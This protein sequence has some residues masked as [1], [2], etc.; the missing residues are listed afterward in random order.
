[1]SAMASSF[2]TP[3]SMEEFDDASCTDAM[4]MSMINDEVKDSL[5]LSST[6]RKKC[7][8]MTLAIS[9]SNANRMLEASR[10]LNASLKSQ[11]V[12]S[13]SESSQCNQS[14][15]NNESN[16]R[17]GRN[18]HL[19][20]SAFAVENLVL[21]AKQTSD[22]LLLSFV[23]SMQEDVDNRLLS[24]DEMKL[25]LLL[26]LDMDKSSKLLT[27]FEVLNDSDRNSNSNSKI[28]S[29]SNSNN[30]DSNSDSVSMNSDS[31]NIDD[32]KVK[33]EQQVLN[34]NS[35]DTFDSKKGEVPTKSE[36]NWTSMS[37]SEDEKTPQGKTGSQS[38]SLALPTLKRSQMRKLFQSFLST[39]SVCINYKDM[40]KH[41]Q[42]QLSCRQK[43]DKDKGSNKSI[44]LDENDSPRSHQNVKLEENINEPVQANPQ[45]MNSSGSTSSPSSNFRRDWISI[46]RDTSR[47]IEDIANH[48]TDKVIEDI[49]KKTKIA[50][51]STSSN[52]A[53]PNHTSEDFIIEF[54]KFG[55][56]YNSGGFSLVPWLELL[57]LA[58][59]DYAGRAA[60]SAAAAASAKEKHQARSSNSTQH[61]Q[62]RVPPPN[63]AMD[64]IME[65]TVSNMMP[66]SMESGLSP[67]MPDL[68]LRSPTASLMPSAHKTSSPLSKVLITF[69][70]AGSSDCQIKITTENLLQLQHLVTV[71]DLSRRSPGQVA[72]VLLR[73]SKR[74]R[75]KTSSFNSSQPNHEEV[76]M[77]LSR[78]DF[79]H[80]IRDLIPSETLRR[81]SPPEL[82][83]VMN[84]FSSFFLCFGMMNAKANVSLGV[85]HVNAKE[86]AVGLSF[87]CSGN[88][89]AK[90][91]STFEL[92]GDQNFAHLS[93]RKLM[94]YLRSYLT[95]LVSISLLHSSEASTIDTL[96]CLLAMEKRSQLNQIKGRLSRLCDTVEIGARWTLDHFTQKHLTKRK[97]N[98]QGSSGYENKIFFE[99]FAS[100]YTDGG[101]TIAPWLEFLDLKKFML[102]LNENEHTKFT[103]PT[104]KQN[105]E[106]ALNSPSESGKI[107]TFDEY[108]APSPAPAPTSKRNSKTHSMAAK[109]PEEDILFTFPLAKKESLVVLREDAAYVRTV[110]DHLGL[111]H[112]SPEDVWDCL[113]GHVT[114]TPPPPLS[115]QFAQCHKSGTGKGCDVNQKI[116]VEAVQKMLPS[117]SKRKRSSTTLASTPQETLEN[118][119]QSFDLD[120]VDRVSANQLMGGLTLLC[121]G[122]KSAKLAFAFGLF[123]MRNKAETK[124][125]GKKTKKQQTKSNDKSLCGKEV[126]YF[127]RSFLIV[128]FSCCKQSL[129]LSADA[130]SRYISDTA[131]MVTDDVMK[132]QWRVRRSERV[133]F[134][135]F[136]DWYNEGGFE[137]APWLELLDLN[138][139]VLL[140]QEKAEKLIA[141]AK[142]MKSRGAKRQLKDKSN[143]PIVK[144]SVSPKKHTSQADFPVSC[145]PP[146]PDDEIDPHTDSFFDDI[147]MDG[148][149]GDIGDMGF[150]FPEAGKEN[151]EQLQQ[152]GLETRST[153]PS[154]YRM[155]IKEKEQKPLKFQLFTNESNAYTVSINPKRVLL[156]KHLVIESNL[157]NIAISSACSTIL[158]DDNG[159]QISRD[160]FDSAMHNVINDS[161]MS[162]ESRTLLSDLLTAVFNAFDFNKLGKADATELACGLTVLCGGRKSDKLEYAFEL[163]D[164]EKK[165]TVS[166]FQMVR[167]LQSFLLVLLNISSCSL[168]QE[169]SEDILHNQEGE[170][171]EGSIALQ[172]VICSASSWATEEIFKATQSKREIKEGTEHI[173]FD[174]FADWYTGGGYN[175]I[176]WL[177]L[178]DLKKWVLA[179]S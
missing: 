81:L 49:Q 14:D 23:E 48:A 63:L 130:V 39:I 58:K 57:D 29:N 21:A 70:F 158:G 38:S 12:K 154:P 104:G 18:Q 142:P 55:D 176:A 120:Q 47:E 69:D 50:S 37:T 31:S 6:M 74:R 155:G 43:M 11:K 64:T 73:H 35:D 115:Y 65:T 10:A 94:K 8:S 170:K 76:M 86:L 96:N 109:Q 79:G 122:K 72:N 161:I 178:L 61:K 174:N 30:N 34:S 62:D 93:Q 36:D 106:V 16:Q 141:E 68:F 97:G 44:K 162:K 159:R 90:L 139:W 164:K 145:P 152:P 123:D 27:A 125:K 151:M 56:W 138:K 83:S 33:I 19:G 15:Q 147:E 60:A 98:H 1:M 17:H 137:T 32:K 167:Y 92:I 172:K 116:F 168:G 101:Y 140:D 42:Q 177:E 3:F 84:R 132:H 146:P 169:P 77:V 102:L 150:L 41:Q 171:A 131:N 173:D 52:S 22:Q 111:L 136:G 66:D 71:T 40:G 128:M 105:E 85:D 117:K 4:A 87:L 95:M 156:L 20:S 119:F 143:D 54:Q 166:R 9:A 7:T 153:E 149:G 82:N 110:V 103:R 134:D 2:Q 160:R 127:L 157:C 99:D 113:F 45:S 108:F 107:R 53:P 13:K 118:F 126:F 133:N 5:V 26:F 135:D 25:R 88:K 165:G 46:S 75:I 114:K 175:R 100:W 59:W 78:Q 121:G 67:T 129:D 89:S 112:L 124:T 148:I 91:A 163:L 80:C 51:D 144:A 24:K 28:S 179:E